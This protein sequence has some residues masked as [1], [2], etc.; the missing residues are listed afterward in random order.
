MQ[1]DK[2]S[3]DKSLH[4]TDEVFNSSSHMAAAVF[5]VL[6]AAF[7]ITRSAATGQVWHIVSFSIYGVSL[8]AVFLFSTLHHGVNSNQRTEMILRNCDYIA[9]FPLI[10]GSYTPI[11]L[12]L[13]RDSYIGW[14]IFGVIWATAVLGI[15]LR[16]GFKSLPEWVL[17][18]LYITMGWLGAF[19]AIP[20]YRHIGISGFMLFLGGGL[21]YSIGFVIYNIEK[22][23]PV[24]GKFGFHEIWHIFV[25]LGALA[26]FLMMMLL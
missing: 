20:I 2:L 22:P 15:T 19:V 23:N 21:F 6:G 8:F 9:I 7:L 18:T 26:H 12:I 16:A 25:I 1:T 10:A 11:C 14:T 13:L 3:K 4:V 24:P 5:S 17:N